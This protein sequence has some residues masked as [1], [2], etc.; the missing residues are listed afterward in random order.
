[1]YPFGGG[2][3]I[4]VKTTLTVLA[5]AAMLGCGMAP[6][7]GG[8]GNSKKA[9]EAKKPKKD[10][11]VIPVEVSHPTRGDISEYFATN[12][13][14]QAERQVEVTSEGVGKCVS[15][16]VEEGDSVEKGQVLAELDKE[17]ALASL[18]QAKVNLAQQEA[19]HTRAK[20]G[21]E[22]GLVS[23]QDLD[24]ARFSFENAQANLKVQEVQL[25]NLTIKAPIDGVVTT[26]S[27]QT[28]MLVS[29]GTP[30]FSVVDP[31]SYQLVIHPPEKELPRLRV[32][33][34][35]KFTVD[36]LGHEE[37]EARISRINPSVDLQS[38]TIKVTLSLAEETQARLRESAFTRV[39]LVMETH[40]AALLV[41][42]DAIVE[43]NAR[44]YVFTVVE[45]E[46]EPEA[47]VEDEKESAEAQSTD[48]E[49]PA[50]KDDAEPEEAE[51][52]EEGP[53]VQ[54]VAKRVEVETGLE[55]SSFTEVVSGIEE[56]TLIVTLGQQT[57]KPDA[58]VR[59]T[60]SEQEFAAKA[61]LGV[62]EALNLAKEEREKKG[63]NPNA[64]GR[65]RRR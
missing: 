24:A 30:A 41:P 52:E 55:D 19:A 40:E 50:D 6:G 14:V 42:K 53:R 26:K 59:P 39:R 44:T 29:S 51:S 47:E 7:K 34:V 63:T 5:L 61:S 17:E 58:K 18:R 60:T 12:S 25:N 33:Q 54:H 9:D 38:G 45:E 10:E 35:A 11:I 37:F 3:R 62:D 27:I 65:R 4:G 21:H 22:Q 56:D 48:S 64:G 57:L 32:G 23:D 2:M 13:W 15:V 8:E 20:G 49:E 16:F 46:V 28:G 36:A 31:S 43:E 1:M